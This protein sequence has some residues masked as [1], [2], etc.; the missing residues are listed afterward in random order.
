MTPTQ[1]RKKIAL[2]ALLVVGILLLL[3]G[4]FR[5]GVWEL[6]VKPESNAGQSVRLKGAVN[7]LGPKTLDFVTLGDSRVV[8]GLEHQRVA[9]A[10][11]A[12]GFQHANLSMPGSHWMTISAILDWLSGRDAQL[13]GAVIAMS[14]ASFQYSGNGQYEFA[15]A[16]PFMKQWDSQRLNAAAQFDRYQLSTYG[17]Y[18]ALFQYRDDIQN[19]LL[20]PLRRL[21]E[22]HAYSRQGVQSLHY[23]VKTSADM[24]G[25]A[26]QNIAACAA[27]LPKKDSDAGV[28]NHC[29]SELT[30]AKNQQDWR[31]WQSPDAIPHLT[32]VAKMRQ[33]EL[34][35]MKVKKPIL[36]IL[37]PET[38]L[39]RDELNPKGLQSFTQYLLKPLVADGTIV[40]HDFTHFFDQ[41]EGG[42]CAVFWDLLHQNT[43]GQKRLTDAVLPI[44]EAELYRTHSR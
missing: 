15:L 4:L 31:Q 1:I 30:N 7:E 41:T 39:R 18:S 12:L 22:K 10:A 9:D 43:L 8:Y 20:Q 34:R 3:E 5:L 27:A 13:K 2:I 26:M 35:A 36:F 38:K 23:S 37:M 19:L 32:A 40:L 6:F 17:V 24:C 16:I 44:I 33:D 21:K 42:E 29:K 14:Y 28:I 11:K 25:I